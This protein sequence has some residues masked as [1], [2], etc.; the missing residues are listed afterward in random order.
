MRKEMLISA[1]I[2]GMFLILFVGLYDLYRSDSALAVG[3]EGPIRLYRTIG[4]EGGGEVVLKPDPGYE[5]TASREEKIDIRKPDLNPSAAADGPLPQYG[6]VPSRDPSEYRLNQGLQ[7]EPNAVPEKIVGWVCDE[8]ARPVYGIL[9]QAGRQLYLDDPNCLSETSIRQLASS[10]RICKVLG[11][12][13]RNGLAG[14]GGGLEYC[15]YHPGI[16]FRTCMVCGKVESQSL[17][18][19]Q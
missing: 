3:E 5:L 18:Q 1:V 6:N 19:W 12:Q 15:D 16:S 8:N 2:L 14:E 11:H 17:T 7:W 9:L 13:W 4:I 10:G